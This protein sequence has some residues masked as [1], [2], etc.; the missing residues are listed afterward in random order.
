MRKVVFDIETR[1]DF[2]GIGKYDPALLTI[3]VVGIHDSETDKYRSF[4]VEEFA[5]LWP[6]LE[7]TDMLIGYNSDH[8]DIPI[9]NK[10]YPGDL[11]AIKSLDLL[12]EIKET[13]GR[14]LRL[15]SVAEATLGTNKSASGLQALE[16][17]KEGE[18]Q[19]IRDYC[20]DD[21]R[22]TKE[23][24]DYARANGLV[25]Y[26]DGSSVRDIK[27]DTSKWEDREDSSLTHT[28]PF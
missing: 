19:K 17:W 15:D 3:S 10:Y 22:I 27:L 11:T 25:K 14:R 28:L 18:I 23:I 4:V 26:K 1:E 8:F 6:I 21:V 9:L 7:K 16:W 5:E 13:L 2:R 12:K 24:Y 20:L